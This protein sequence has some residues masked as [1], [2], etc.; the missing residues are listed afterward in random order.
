M[1]VLRRQNSGLAHQLGA[2][3]QRGH[4]VARVMGDPCQRQGV[5]ALFA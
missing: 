1:A 2:Q 5:T 3:S 4:Q